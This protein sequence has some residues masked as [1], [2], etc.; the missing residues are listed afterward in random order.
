MVS[1]CYGINN[2][3]ILLQLQ[4]SILAH[5][6]FQLYKIYTKNP[7]IIQ[8]FQQPHSSQPKYLH[9]YKSAIILSQFIFHIIMKERKNRLCKKKYKKNQRS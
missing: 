6:L 4:F 5:I 2:T 1:L 3:P 9:S 7:Y 8:N